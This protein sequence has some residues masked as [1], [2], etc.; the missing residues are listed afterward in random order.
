MLICGLFFLCEWE[1]IFPEPDNDFWKMEHSFWYMFL[2]LHWA[3]EHLKKAG[4]LKKLAKSFY[5]KSES[6]LSLIS[7]HI[8]IISDNQMMQISI[9]LWKAV[10]M[11]VS[12]SCMSGSTSA[13]A[14]P[15]TPDRLKYFFFFKSCCF[16]DKVT[17][18]VYI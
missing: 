5:T 11:P 16:H 9:T 3:F 12:T 2:F 1:T 15:R 8:A 10:P 17:S 13:S 18:R 6:N 4:L 14:K 7:L